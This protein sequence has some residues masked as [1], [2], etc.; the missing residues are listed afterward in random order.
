M[1]TDDDESPLTD[2]IDRMEHLCLNSSQHN[3]AIK[4]KCINHIYPS[5]CKVMWQID[6]KHSEAWHPLGEERFIPLRDLS[7]GRH[8]LTVRVLSNE[9]GATLDE[10]ELLITMQPPFYLSFA[11]ILLELFILG[12]ILYQVGR[13][14]KSRNYMQVSEEKINFLINTAH[15]IRT[16]LTLIKAPL[17]ELSQSSTLNVEEREAIGLALR[18][19][20]TLSQMTDKVMQYE[21][22]SIERGVARIERHEAISHF[23]SQIDK[24]AL[25]ARAKQQTICY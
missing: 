8:R 22:S 18:N 17:E 20:N 7:Y 21:L 5:D 15:D 3:A 14:L 19:A 16:P 23:Q 9:S 12:G 25:L 24:H 2:A 1:L 13:Y 10:R 4:V 11:G 6:G